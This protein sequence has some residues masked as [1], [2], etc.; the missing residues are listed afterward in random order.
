MKKRVVLILSCLLLS[1]GFTVAQ[2]TRISGTVV[3]SN[4]E[5]VISA[6]VVVKGTTVGTVTDSDGKFS[7]NV[8]EERS[9]LVFRLVG[10]QTTEAR[11]AANMKVVMEQD[12]N[13]LEE[14]VIN[15]SYGVAK[16]GSQFGAKST[17]SSDRLEV[18]LTSFD[19]ALQGNAAG[20]QSISN[21]G[22]PGAGQQVIIRGVGT[23]NGGTTPLYVLDGIAIATGNLGNMTQTASTSSADN[24][25][26]LSNLNPNDIEN[27]TIL[28][29]AASTAIYG[30][31]ASNGV[32][33]ITTKK[34]KA[35]KTQFNLKMST[36][37]SSR[38]NSKLN[39]MNKDQYIDYLTEA[40]LNAGY[41]DGTTK[42]NGKDIN[43]FIANNFRVR[44]AAGDLY[45]FDWQDATF[46]N[47][48]PVSTIDFSARGGNEK[49]KF[50]LSLSMLDQDGIVIDTYLK[51]YTGRINLDHTVNNNVKLGLNTVGSYNVQRSPMTTGG[52]Y[53]SPVFG[54]A[55]YSPLDAGIIAA[56]SSLYN[57]S[58][59][60]LTPLDPGPN[61]DYITT[62]ANA[63]FLANSA[64]DDFSSRTARNITNAYAQWS[65]LND[66]I[67]K[68]TVGYDYYYLTEEEWRDARPKG[69]SASYGHGL[70]ETSVTE[71]YTWNE[72]ITLNYIK[73]IADS[74]NLN[75]LAGQ[76][77]QGEGYRYSGGIAQDFP[78]SY[79]H[80]MS[81]GATPYNVYGARFASTLASFFGTVNY[82]FDQKYYL[83]ASLRSDGSSRLSKDNRWSTFWSV[84]GSW[85]VNKENFLK[86]VNLINNLAL[87]ASYG[88]SG[89]QSG[90]SRYAALAL[91]SGVGYNAGS[92]LYPSQIEN[93]K[94]TWEKTA[95][96]D[97]GLEFS[98]FN[99]RLDGTIDWYRRNTTD[100]L[101]NTQLSRT[102]GFE[103]ITS[104]VGELYNTGIEVALNGTIV[105]TKDIL[106]KLG[107]NI[108]SNKNRITKLY[109]GD[110]I[111]N[112]QFI[113]RE[114]EDVH[115]LYTYRWAGV[116]PADGR[117]M[118]YDKDGEIMYAYNEKGD[119]REI[120]GSASP[121]FYGG[122]N[123]TLNAFG[124]D[125]SMSFY[126]TYGNK[127]YDAS[128]MMFT[129]A[130]NRGLWNQYEV[131]AT[132]R[133]RKEGDIVAHPK[134]YYGYTSTVYG[135]TT[136]KSVFDGSYIRLRDL[137]L[138]YNMP[139]KWLRPVGLEGL[140]IY[141]QG[142]NLLTFTKFPDYDPEV[143]GGRLAGYYYLGYPNARTITFG[144]D[145][146]F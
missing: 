78:G 131:V 73:T 8:S 84:G 136:D 40:R 43:S 9:I 89:N 107:F 83:S 25:N 88:T 112:G 96:I 144:L 109:E 77:T 120:V 65:F 75:F 26:P 18:P 82:D 14:I 108:T 138:G 67:L 97:L 122:L 100:A 5:P 45:D 91:Y 143:G 72:N 85:K 134:A 130:G 86:D 94:L 22:Q 66:F 119:T 53:V 69:N 71:Q 129:S 6:T 60:T 92:G 127:V 52:Y 3:D 17:I 81:Q 135:T 146:K 58:N 87:R 30:S 126:Y 48:A 124:F 44:N 64:Y 61:I 49:T 140:R 98:V 93:P 47:S 121:K 74:H 137:T 12:E 99:N 132:D 145:V 36:G 39:V 142:T 46:K 63:N 32:V 20:V 56:G 35:G 114:G 125:L 111:I 15:A 113:Y 16:S 128:W 104:N 33:F 19:K 116:N 76:E 24:L 55:M 101:L 79:F 38:T 29:D 103:N 57:S 42:V 7:I 90:I 80:Y 115:S 105:R 2:T 34:G 4:G 95:S 37:F 133:W 28:K 102:T 1:V 27:I 117:P 54:A 70:A 68:G 41:S 118:Y 11:A 21:S 10:M 23:I 62:Y 59:G 139:V 13:V 141:M 51:R 31:R 50:F 123:T 110:D 106:W